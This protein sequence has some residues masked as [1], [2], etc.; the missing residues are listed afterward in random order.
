MTAPPEPGSVTAE[1]VLLP[2]WRRS[3]LWVALAG[4]I[5]LGGLI[6]ALTRPSPGLPLDP[7]LPSKG[8]GKA[9]AVLLQQHGTTVQRVTAL[10]A[11]TAGS[12]V[13]VSSPD[14]YDTTQLV[15]LIVAGHHVVLPRP[16]EQLV[17]GI[18]QRLSIADVDAAAT[19]LAPDCSDP[20]AVA[21]G[22][23]EFPAGA[24]RYGG[25]SGCFGGRVLFAG[26]L[27]VLGSAALLRN[28]HLAAT[29][30][31]ALAMNALSTDSSGRTAGSLSWLMPGQDAGGSGSPSIWSLFPDWTG[32]GAAWLLLTGVLLAVWRGRRLGPP[33]TEPL[34]VIV[35]AAEIVEGHGRLYARAGATERAGELLRA[36]SIHR[37]RTILGL[38]AAASPAAVV[39][40]AAGV[41]DRATARP[42]NGWPTEVGRLLVGPYPVDDAGLVG[43][44]A[45]LDRVE[46]ELTT[47]L[48]KDGIRD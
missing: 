5:L 35:R 12:T 9:L 26:R 48:R 1:R 44:A 19:T 18:D 42:G 33:V 7:D 22:T 14:A 2:L 43:F 36:A 17:S 46:S 39:A 38:A 45:E 3:R 4:L 13:L 15:A 28:D 31:A 20:G 41:L 11:I 8:G 40:E 34:P 32:R 21:A 23:V 37:L 29:G 6:L 16:S 27:T 25:A 10:S 30:V 24:A 47:A